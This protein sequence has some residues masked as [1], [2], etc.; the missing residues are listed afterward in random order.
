MTSAP[1]TPFDSLQARRPSPLGES[2]IELRQYTLHPG[3]RDE[4]IDLFE[5]EFIESQEACGIRVLGQFR[6]LDRPD[7]FVWLRGF[8]DIERRRQ[9]LAAFYGGP[10]WKA[11]RTAANA[12]MIDSDD[13]LL[14]QPIHADIGFRDVGLSTPDG[15]RQPSWVTVTLCS[16]PAPPDAASLEAFRR[17]L[18]SAD[19]QD[20]ARSLGGYMTDPGPNTF[21]ALPVREGEQVLVWFSGFDDPHAMERSRRNLRASP[22]WREAVEAQCGV[23]RDTGLSIVRLA[24]TEK[25]RIR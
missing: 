20:G 10:V 8:P 2:L 14:L 17:V 21:P 9:S 3:R 23:L 6:D 12:T 4:L 22:V 1:L 25:S 13:V 5:R 15:D 7:H 19:T 16:L 18:Q 11:H 24:P